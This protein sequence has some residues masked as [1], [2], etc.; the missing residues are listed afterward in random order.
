MVRSQPLINVLDSPH[1]ARWPTQ[2]I[3]AIRQAH[4]RA[5]IKINNTDECNDYQA[6]IARHTFC[7]ESWED[8]FRLP[9]ALQ[10]A[11]L[12]VEGRIRQRTSW[13]I[14]Q[15]THRIGNSQNAPFETRS[16]PLD[17]ASVLDAEPMRGGV[18][19]QRSCRDPD[20]PCL[21]TALVRRRTER[22]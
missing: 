14:A 1:M 3:S 17:Q 20:R 4:S 15:Q 2:R 7:R 10:Q 8:F 13:T 12:E 11:K 22:S 21:R 18:V 6:F 9:E 5:S 19:I 16:L